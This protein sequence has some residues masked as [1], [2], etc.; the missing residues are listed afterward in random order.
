MKTNIQYL[1]IVFTALLLSLSGNKKR[2]INN[3]I[4]LFSFQLSLVSLCISVT[5]A[6][7]ENIHKECVASHCIDCSNAVMQQCYEQEIFRFFLQ[8]RK[9]FMANLAGLERIK[10]N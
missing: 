8:K 2:L 6:T 5:T 4:V 7:K 3:P 1:E 10:V 9:D